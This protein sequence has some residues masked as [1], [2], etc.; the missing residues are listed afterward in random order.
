[1]EGRGPQVN[2]ISFADDAML[3]ISERSKTLQ[4]IMQTLKTYDDILY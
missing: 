4:P 2:H 3:F 1:M